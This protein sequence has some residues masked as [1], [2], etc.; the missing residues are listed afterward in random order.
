MQYTENQISQ[1]YRWIQVLN[2]VNPF[3]SLNPSA[4][5]RRFWTQ[6]L[7]FVGSFNSFRWTQGLTFVD[8]FKSMNPRANLRRF[9]TQVLNFVGSFNSIRWT[10]VLN[11]V[12]PFTNKTFKYNTST[13]NHTNMQVYHLTTVQFQ[14]NS[15]MHMTQAIQIMQQIIDNMAN[16]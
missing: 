15:V 2:F 5:L 14:F 12:D 11:F 8:P 10:Q 6:V 16:E 4:K 13:D 1:S 7:N 9:W 3:K